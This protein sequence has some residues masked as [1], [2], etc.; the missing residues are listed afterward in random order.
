MDIGQ[1]AKL[2]NRGNQRS[3][4]RVGGEGNGMI[5]RFLRFLL[6]AAVAGSPAAAAEKGF[7]PEA[8]VREPTRLDWAFAA[9]AE[10]GKLPAGYD[11]R[12]LRY[13]RYVPPAYSPSR[14]WPLVL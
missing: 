2:G 9:G 10:A 6:L 7:E 4:G 8:R 13:Q 12:R 11:S 14:A 5:V 1:L 3:R